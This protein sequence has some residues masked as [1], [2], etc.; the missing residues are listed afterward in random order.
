[1]FSVGWH[2]SVLHCDDNYKEVTTNQKKAYSLGRPRVG[3]N[4]D[5][6]ARTTDF[7]WKSPVSGLS[8][9]EILQKQSR[10]ADSS[11]KEWLSDV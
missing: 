7:D 1:M 10:T 2:P 9:W 5:E 8:L 4:N 6:Y 11:D 3:D